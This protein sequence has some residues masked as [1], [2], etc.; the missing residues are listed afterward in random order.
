MTF[1]SVLT[2]RKQCR[3]SNW[4][5]THFVLL[6]YELTASKYYIQISVK[7]ENCAVFNNT[8]TVVPNVA[9][10][11]DTKFMIRSGCRQIFDVLITH[12]RLLSNMK[13]TFIPP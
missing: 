1:Y 8:V 7:A 4:H 6:Y 3:G 12:M 9:L 11:W 5:R 13:K 2:Q 10:I